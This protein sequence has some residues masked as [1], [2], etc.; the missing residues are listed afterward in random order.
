MPLRQRKTGAQGQHSGTEARTKAQPH[1]VSISAHRALIA[2]PWVLVASLWLL[3]IPT[4]LP[5]QDE[6]GLTFD[7]GLANFESGGFRMG[8]SS[9]QVPTILPPG[10][11]ATEC[12]NSLNYPL[13]PSLPIESRSPGE[14]PRRLHLAGAPPHLRVNM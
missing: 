9:P 11:A 12:R 6:S 2:A 1:P 3:L 8:V 13:P 10:S 7:V 5:L 14:L 4:I